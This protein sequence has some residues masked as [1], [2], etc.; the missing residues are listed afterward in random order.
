MFGRWV[1]IMVIH[2]G[3][4]IQ[5]KLEILSNA[6]KYDVACTSS[7]VDRKGNK[8][9]IGNSLACGICHT[10]SADG[11]CISL[12]KI[13][14]T[15]EC[16]FDCKYCINRSSN[17]IVR[18]S[19][20]PEEL[21]QLT[22]EFYRRNYIE[23]LFLSSGIKISPNHTMELMFDTLR[24]LR[25]D[26]HFN[27]YIHC[28]AIPGAD[29]ALIEALGW[30]ADRM[31]VNLELPTAS[32]LKQLAPHKNRKNILKPI[33]QIQLR[34][35]SNIEYLGLYDKGKSRNYELSYKDK[36]DKSEG[37]ITDNINNKLLAYN[38]NNN[39][40]ENEFKEILK[41]A[42]EIIPSSRFL[43]AG[44][45]YVPAGQ[46]T[47]MII[48]A[49]EDSDYHIM[50]VSEALYNNFDLKRVFYSAFVNVNQDSTLPS[51]QTG[52]P[53]L[54]EH[55]LYQADWLLRFYGFKTRELLDEK[56]PNFNILL[57]PKCDWALK[58]LDKFP[59]EINKAD[60]YTLLRVPGIGVKSARRIIAARKNAVLDFKDLKK[61]GIVLKR[62][63]YFITCKGKMMY[64]IKIDEDFI[65]RELLSTKDRLPFGIDKD[66]TYRQLSLFDDMKY[67]LSQG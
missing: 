37:L 11:R 55:R 13:L 53:L 28:K 4:S 1:Q 9:G 25:E 46:S 52:P 50:S 63:V 66:I 27:G 31:S 8:S 29:P 5:R 47:Q 18:T 17:D 41:P 65:T 49:T 60:Y 40:D 21:C 42:N 15:N 38:G 7:G 32:S 16:I 19:F 12:L 48:G 23:G 54:R 43:R 20:T 10:F 51:T 64:P 39:N 33:R 2:E 6:A 14:F 35:E 67:N 34:R 59:V 30:Y 24:K 22:M 44:K 56:K 26:Y 45:R 3:M 57:D 62:A 61:L 36:T 58:N